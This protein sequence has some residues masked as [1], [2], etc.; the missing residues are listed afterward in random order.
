MH[1]SDFEEMLAQLPLPVPPPELRTKLLAHAH[2]Q[3]RLSFWQRVWGWSLAAITALLLALNLYISHIQERQI[4]ALVG[5]ATVEKTMDM[6]RLWRHRLEQ[7]S[8]LSL[9]EAEL[10]G[11]NKE[12]SL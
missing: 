10:M 5:P 4:I 6:D 12:R 7:Q 1:K 2:R 3:Q 11:E 9:L 8:Q